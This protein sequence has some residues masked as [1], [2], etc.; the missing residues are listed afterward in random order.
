MDSFANDTCLLS[1]LTD[2]DVFEK[3][4]IS[5]T[6]VYTC[7]HIYQTLN[8]FDDFKSYYKH[9]REVS[10]SNDQSQYDPQ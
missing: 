10:Q 2:S 4:H 3:L 8:C 1:L 7:R 5:F 6:P 9:N